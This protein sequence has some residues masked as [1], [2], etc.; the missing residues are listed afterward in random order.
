MGTPT[1]DDDLAL[2]LPALARVQR[3]SPVPIRLEVIGGA[4]RPETW[5]R[6]RSLPF[7]VRRLQP[8]SPLYPSFLA[9]FGATVRWDIA[10]APLCDTIFNSC[11][12]DVKFLDYSAVGA[13]GVYSRS[14]AYASVGHGETGLLSDNSPD[15]WA[16]ALLRLLRQPALRGELSGA[17]WRHLYQQRVLARRVNDWL[18][19][20]EQVWYA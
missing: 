4:A 8:P 18:A 11:K 16:D 1:H 15:A 2:I 9:W 20:L 10:L 14:P 19:G 5:Q 13:A 7:P 12:S 3:Q 6:L 17:A